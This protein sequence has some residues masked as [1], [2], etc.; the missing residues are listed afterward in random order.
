M[1]WSSFIAAGS[2]YAAACSAIWVGAAHTE[3]VLKKGGLEAV[4]NAIRSSAMASAVIELP[5]QF[6]RIFGRVFTERVF[7]LRGFSRSA[8]ASLIFV[9]CLLLYAWS[10]IPEAVNV[11]LTFREPPPPPPPS[12]SGADSGSWAYLVGLDFHTKDGFPFQLPVVSLFLLPL[13]YNICADFFAIVLTQRA[14]TAQL[15]LST[16]QRLLAFLLTAIALLFTSY[17]FF[18]LSMTVSGVVEWIVE[19]YKLDNVLSTLGSDFSWNTRLYGMALLFP[20]SPRFAT[21]FLP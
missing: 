1:S 2:T 9:T 18:V 13:L 6:I 4:A 14:L 5:K 20:F 15:R 8:I 11:T 17:V 10:Q 21:H 19:G 16:R 3:K 7:S 12:G